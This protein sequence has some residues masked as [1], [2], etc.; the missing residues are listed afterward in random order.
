MPEKI[1]A[2]V[3]RQY[4]F[5]GLIVILLGAVIVYIIWDR[6]QDA[7]KEKEIEDKKKSGDYVSFEEVR[8]LKEKMG[9]HLAKEYVEG[10]RFV[11]IEAKLTAQEETNGHL[12][13]QHKSLFEG[14]AELNKK[15]DDKTDKLADKIDQ[16]FLVINQDIK[17]ILAEMRK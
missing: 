16:R 15:V 11:K 13:N 12:F 2:E 8:E 3:Y 4:G 10:E 14:L 1:A 5:M 7:K 6:L 9:N 17:Q